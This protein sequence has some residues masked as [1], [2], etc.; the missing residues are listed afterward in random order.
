M[1]YKAHV[2]S[3]S[4][5]LIL[6]LKTAPARLFMYDAGNAREPI[7]IIAKLA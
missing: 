7:E 4:R 2:H 6:L 1:Y 5:L 3:K